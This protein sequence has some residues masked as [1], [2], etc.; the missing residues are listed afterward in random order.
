MKRT[1]RLNESEL[2]K[3]IYESVKRV[4]N[5]YDDTISGIKDI[6]R[7]SKFPSKYK[8]WGDK[9]NEDEDDELEGLTY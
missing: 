8:R 3:M 1:I 4:L 5:E 9:D 6:H 7:S 2:K